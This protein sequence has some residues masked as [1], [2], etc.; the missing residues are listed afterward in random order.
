MEHEVVIHRVV[1]VCV[2]LLAVYV[3]MRIF[4]ELFKFTLLPYQHSMR[5]VTNIWIWISWNL[6][7]CIILRVFFETWSFLNSALLYCRLIGNWRELKRRLLKPKRKKQ[8]VRCR[9]FFAV[10]HFSANNINLIVT[11][12]IL[13]NQ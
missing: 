11:L 8:I 10:I 4:V 1:C 9:C 6:F 2:L 3:V 7:I 12:Y 5:R 13:I